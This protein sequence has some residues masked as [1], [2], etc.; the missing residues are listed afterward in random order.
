MADYL[1]LARK[2]RSRTFEEVIAQEHVARVLQ[3]AIRSGR[4]AHAYLFA[5]TRGVGKTTVARILAKALNCLSSAAPTP[6]PC[7]TCDACQ[8]IFRG[9]DIDVIEIDGASNRGIE[10]IRELRANAVFRPSRSRFR[11]YYIDEVHMLTTPAF[12][13]LLKTLEEPPPHVKFI[14]AT[15][16]PEKI[17][18]TI[19]SRCQRFDFRSIPT[20]RIAE[21]LEGICHQEQVKADKDALLR[22]ARAGA[23]SMRDSLSL[24]DQILAAAG[25][26]TDEQVTRVLGAPSEQRTL[27]IVRAVA[28]GDAA[29]ALKEFDAV[30]ELGL[31][32]PSAVAAVGELFR[33]L[34]LMA[35]CGPQSDL[36][37][38]PEATRAELAQLAGSF[39]LP[40]LV[41]AVAVLGTLERSV[42]TLDLGR[43]MAEATLVRL[44]QAEKFTDPASLLERIESLSRGQ[45]APAAAQKKKPLMS[46]AAAVPGR[47]ESPRGPVQA[48]SAAAGPALA[49]L[50]TEEKNQLARDPAVRSVMSLFGGQ[51]VD[52][53]HDPAQAQD[54]QSQ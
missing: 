5:G 44:A 2:Y 38:L 50:T 51:V 23:G 21:H 22:I 16:E 3:Q 43:A 32:L 29:G 47:D 40:A 11:I 19:L 1:V 13:A 45:A 54:R 30:L 27:G 8:A 7:N 48:N 35:S 10:E 49:G 33:N 9:D 6:Q 42:R 37:E 4:I 31:G 41:G 24:L 34:M 39:S 28:G 53:R 25:E 46:P 12:N 14:F 18:A 20:R 52:I 26:V 17:P 36:V 15:T